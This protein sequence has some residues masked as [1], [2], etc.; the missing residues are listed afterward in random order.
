MGSERQREHPIRNPASPRQGLFALGP[1]RKWDPGGLWSSFLFSFLPRPG[2][3][4]GSALLPSAGERFARCSK[5]PCCFLLIMQQEFHGLSHCYEEIAS[6]NYLTVPYLRDGG[7]SLGAGSGFVNESLALREA[8]DLS[9][10]LP[11][12][13]LLQEIF[14]D[15]SRIFFLF[16]PD[17]SYL[18]TRKQ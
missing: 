9:K 18:W 17:R 14:N 3:R 5:K 11:F 13:F 16:S 1:W 7:S 8:R 2:F 6:S 12:I 4:P 10:S 15:G